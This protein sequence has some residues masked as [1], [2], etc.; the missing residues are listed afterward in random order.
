MKTTLHALAL[1]TLFAGAAIPS[2]ARA[3]PRDIREADARAAANRWLVSPSNQAVGDALLEWNQ[4]HP[5]FA[6]KLMEWGYD[7]CEEFYKWF[8]AAKRSDA[9][10]D[11]YVKAHPTDAALADLI[12]S[13]EAGARLFGAFGRR[14]AGRLGPLESCTPVDKLFLMNSAIDSLQERRV[15]DK[16]AQARKRAAANDYAG[17]IELFDGA[18][19]S[20]Q[21]PL[22]EVPAIIAELASVQLL[23]GRL[24]E[25]EKNARAAMTPSQGAYALTKPQERASVLYTLGRIQEKRGQKDQAMESYQKSLELRPNSREVQSHLSALKSAAPA[26]G[27]AGK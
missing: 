11:A 8:A 1:A 2:I 15:R 20:H 14:F 4:A 10:G 27:P 25:A 21:L 13:D 12:K 23:A 6:A 18:I 5:E 24:D 7:H 17:A 22:V 19:K 16:L 9:A 26:P 3:M